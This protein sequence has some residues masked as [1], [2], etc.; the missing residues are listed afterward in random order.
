MKKQFVSRY[1]SICKYDNSYF[2]DDLA[3]IIDTSYGKLIKFGDIERNREELQKTM[4]AY[5]EQFGEGNLQKLYYIELRVKREQLGIMNGL[6]VSD[7]TSILNYLINVSGVGVIRLVNVI[8]SGN[9]E[10]LLKTADELRR[11]GY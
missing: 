9:M 5:K 4:I 1:G 11:A 7:I 2:M 10:E 8:R 3:V 6:D